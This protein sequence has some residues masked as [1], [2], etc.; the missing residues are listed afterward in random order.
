MRWR[1]NTNGPLIFYLKPKK[2]II[3]GGIHSVIELIHEITNGLRPFVAGSS[4]DT[5]TKA[6]LEENA[7]LLIADGTGDWTFRSGNFGYSSNGCDP[8]IFGNRQALQKFLDS[9][10]VHGHLVL[11]VSRGT[12][13]KVE[14]KKLG[15]YEG[16]LVK[17]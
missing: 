2:E 10:D 7:V 11:D 16:R 17:E 9:N 13:F 4:P 1:I 8:D 6:V 5:A 12:W 15:Q 14:Q 3:N